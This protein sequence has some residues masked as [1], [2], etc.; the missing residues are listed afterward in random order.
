MPPNSK[1]SLLKRTRILSDPFSLCPSCSR[2][3]RFYTPSPTE[4]RQRQD[5]FAFVNR[6]AS[7]FTNSTVAHVSRNIPQ[8]YQELYDALDELRKTATNH[9]NLSRL[10]LAQRGL[11]VESPLIR[12]AILG[13]GG[14][15]IALKLAR[16]LLADPLSPKAEWESY[17]S[18]KNAGS[19]TGLLIRYGEKFEISSA[20]DLL[21]TLSIPS[22]LLQRANLEILISPLDVDN[23][24]TP[25]SITRA[26]RVPTIA[27]PSTNTGVRTVIRY[28]VHKSII[29]GDGIRDLLKFG[30]ISG[31]LNSKDLGSTRV[32]FQLGLNSPQS[33][34]ENV[35]VVDL[36]SG[37][38]A[39][40]KFRQ[41]VKNSQDYQEGWEQSGIQ[42]LLDWV[43]A[44]RPGDGIMP[45]D[46]RDLMVSVLKETDN[47][48]IEDEEGRIREQKSAMLPD[49]TQRTLDAAISLWAETAHTELRTS[50][51]Q[52]FS[53]K[54]WRNLAWWKLFWRVDDV[55]MT[56]SALIA[57][58]W[59]VHAEKE[60]LWIGG[61]F[62]QAGLFNHNKYSP[63]GE[64]YSSPIST[65]SPTGGLNDSWPAQIS[66]DRNRFILSTI[67]SIQSL[68]QS[69]VMFSLSTTGLTSALSAL[70]YIS[71][72]SATLYEAGTI[73][74]VGLIYSLR[75][76]QKHWDEARKK[77]QV[78]VREE[79]RK[80]LKRT[81]DSMRTMLMEST[82]PSPLLIEQEAKD[83]VQ[84]ARRA[85]SN[86]P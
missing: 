40:D 78:E 56:Y 44:S 12:I 64:S 68:A 81:E 23:D 61:R 80:S 60:G 20:S 18:S 26:V 25:D 76:Q 37:E 9:V 38:I 70:T 39:L 30:R 16:L 45:I 53:S 72:P 31:G 69:L 73:A 4:R 59:L 13:L 57:K 82:Q 86:V 15:D 58:Q 6:P 2:L 22:I 35:S 48:I 65:G 51:D 8:K 41:S 77:W 14:P 42:P 63:V 55:A 5:K 21:P 33:Q 17:L 10:Q 36:D 52:A 62:Q 43:S 32:V 47:K 71:T 74:A 7:T 54:T 28:P 46:L 34:Q 19:S 79:G 84:R 50:L 3:R 85:L 11:E 29:C 66:K 75:R 67:P 83:S 27:I 24:P 49:H 1:T